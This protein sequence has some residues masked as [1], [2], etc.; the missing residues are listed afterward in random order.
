MGLIFLDTNTII[1]YLKGE[2][3][4]VQNIHR[5][6]RTELALPA[7]VLYELEVGT[8]RSVGSKRRKIL[9]KGLQGIDIVPFDAEA[10]VQAA[11]I[12]VQLESLGISIGPLDI[13]IA[14]AALSRNALLVTN[15]TKEFSRIKGLRVADWRSA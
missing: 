2:P 6:D 14:G 10:A 8:L 15:N 1:H 4:V 11:Q 12:R 3:S 9:E 13:L 7:I 5:R